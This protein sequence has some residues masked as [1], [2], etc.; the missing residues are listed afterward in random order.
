MLPLS[1]EWNI[2]G[3][4]PWQGFA[5]LSAGGI[6]LFNGARYCIYSCHRVIGA[7]KSSALTRLNILLAVIFGIVFLHESVT[8]FLVLGTLSIMMGATIATLEWTGEKGLSLPTKGV[9]YG[10]GGALMSATGGTLIRSVTSTIKAPYATTFVSYM[11]YILVM[12]IVFLFR[13]QQR[14]RLFHLSRFSLIIL[15]GVGTMALIT[16][17]LRFAALSFSPISVVQ[18]LLGTNL[19]FT[20]FFSFIMNRKIDIFN[21]KVFT[22][23]V[24]AAIGVFLISV[25]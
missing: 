5:L 25:R 10:L 16:N 21:R 22:G 12:V 20:F 4:I 15:I 8:T 11:A 7:N 6:V 13:G 9:L 19:L 17:L 2:L 3:T 1:G 14:N 23:I 18:P 24:L